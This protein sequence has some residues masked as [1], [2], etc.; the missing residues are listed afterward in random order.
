[1]LNRTLIRLFLLSI[2]VVT[3]FN[4]NGQQPLK[5]QHDLVVAKDGSGDFRYS[6]DGIDAIL[7]YLPK[8]ITVR[9]K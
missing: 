7:V 1:M 8:H 2:I 9:I 4:T 3:V 5:V 6:Q